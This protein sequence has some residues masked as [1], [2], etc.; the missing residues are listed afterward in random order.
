LSNLKS[1]EDFEF[2]PTDLPFMADVVNCICNV[3]IRVAIPLLLYFGFIQGI[4]MMYGYANDH[5]IYAAS[6]IALAVGLITNLLP[7]KEFITISEEE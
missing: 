7:D 5:A 4:E 1:D 2:N 3:G 6:F